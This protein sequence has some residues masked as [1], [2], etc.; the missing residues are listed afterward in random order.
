[1]NRRSH[2]QVAPSGPRVPFP[3]AI[4]L[5]QCLST[6][7]TQPPGDH[8]TVRTPPSMPTTDDRLRMFA[9]RMGDYVPAAGV[10]FESSKGGP[11]S[12]GIRVADVAEMNVVR[13]VAAELGVPSDA[14]HVVVD[15]TV[16]PSTSYFLTD[17][18]V[19]GARADTSG[20]L[21]LQ[22]ALR[23]LR[24]TVLD[25][26]VE[27]WDLNA[28]DALNI[29]G[30]EG[31]T[32]EGAQTCSGGAGSAP[33]V[34][35]AAKGPRTEVRVSVRAEQLALADAA[36]RTLRAALPSD[37][38]CISAVV[39]ESHNLTGPLP[40]LTFGAS[41]RVKDM[42]QPATHCGFPLVFEAFVDSTAA[43]PGGAASGALPS[44]AVAIIPARYDKSTVHGAVASA[45]GRMTA[46]AYL[47]VN[48]RLGVASAGL[49][50]GLDPVACLMTMD[51]PLTLKLFVNPP[52]CLS[53]PYFTIAN[54]SDAY[55]NARR[56]E[57]GD[58]PATAVSVLV[59]A[60]ADVSLFMI[61]R[62]TTI[63][64]EDLVP[65][66]VSSRT[67][68]VEG[69]ESSKPL[70][71]L[72][73]VPYE[74]ARGPLLFA[75]CTVPGQLRTLHNVGLCVKRLPVA[76]SGG[77]A[78]TSM[79]THICVHDGAPSSGPPPA[80]G[81][82]G[83]PAFRP[84]SIS[85]GGACLEGTGLE[86][87]VCGE[88]V[89]GGTRGSPLRRFYEFTPAAQA[90]AQLRVALAAT[91]DTAAAAALE[92]LQPRELVAAV[93]EAT[94]ASFQR[95]PPTTTTL[96]DSLPTYLSMRP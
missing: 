33:H 54:S 73:L 44:A 16:R 9:T 64:E 5:C 69:L 43:G 53:A 23:V 93:R 62:E 13:Q 51:T 57:D 30:R 15:S 55:P 28:L 61:N 41:V 32:G 18:V 45:K 92:F 1:M 8:F 76:M 24:C 75:G 48:G 2:W 79:F 96:K 22:V 36:V 49:E 60:H 7:P 66:A 11:S 42:P 77:A 85:A 94:M 35:K 89:S 95:G 70:C 46:S 84:S 68:A 63:E 65:V 12:L 52:A 90:L 26:R 38:L 20:E 81:D 40:P 80:H 56:I 74:V 59:A 86:G 47:R 3:K 39:G 82:S 91:G 4:E 14:F 31:C 58:P 6:S 50:L 21:A 17:S 78:P 10:H 83:G 88:C 29:A 72:G 87:F 67:Q 25:A 27:L 34:G 71:V 19:A 37:C